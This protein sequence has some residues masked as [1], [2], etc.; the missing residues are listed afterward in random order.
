MSG[1]ED[2][3]GQAAINLI[4]ASGKAETL[5]QSKPIAECK[6]AAADAPLATDWQLLQR[7]VE[8]RDEAAFA[9]LVEWHGPMVFGVCRRVLGHTQDAED[10]F[11]ATFMA[12]ARRGSAL[13]RRG[14]LAN[15]LHRVA[16]NFAL[17]QREATARR[18]T[19]ET[20]MHDIPQPA[21]APNPWSD[22]EPLLDRELERLPEKYRAAILLCDIEG[23]TRK[24][25]AERLGWPEGTL[26]T[27]LLRARALLASRL[28]RQRI[29]LSAGTLA[30]ILAQNSASA[31]PPATLVSATV[32]AATTTAVVQTAAVGWVPLGATLAV[33]LS[34]AATALAA[35]AAVG[36][37]L[38]AGAGDAPKTAAANSTALLAE[39]RQS[40]EQNEKLLSP[41]TITF[42]K[43]IQTRLTEEET[44]KQLRC[45][46][47]E[48]KL[49]FYKYPS[50]VCWQQ[51]EIITRLELPPGLGFSKVWE[52]FCNGKIQHSANDNGEKGNVV[53]KDSI[54]RVAETIPNS[55][56]GAHSDYF[57]LAGFWTPENYREWTS[58]RVEPDLLH[59]LRSGGKVQSASQVELDGRQV[60][61]VEIIAE[62]P[63][64]TRAEEVNL[65]KYRAQVQPYGPEKAQTLIEAFERQR[66]VP[67]E[68]RFTYFLDPAMGYATVKWQESYESGKPV[69]ECICSDFERIG[70]R[71]LWLPRKCECRYREWIRRIH[72]DVNYP[73]F[74]FEDDFLSEVVEVSE[75]NAAPVESEKLLMA[76]FTPGSKIIDSTLPKAAQ[77][78][79]GSITYKVPEKVDDLP[80]AI[81]TAEKEGKVNQPLNPQPLAAA[82]KRKSTVLWIVAGNAAL[83]LLAGLYLWRRQRAGR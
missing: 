10:A 3:L 29:A 76:Y 48:S 33:K 21:A 80:A 59:R 9:E 32:Q 56:F 19:R 20:P 65:E 2:Y 39:V 72:V 77:V 43:Q 11:Q 17:K 7:F 53:F 18:R 68:K 52:K 49:M 40:L 70:E 28:T 12:L 58:P 35:S 38:L 74:P 79:G 62:N 57:R 51:P 46:E 60:V 27:R 71:A 69:V 8:A 16:R 55:R 36:V 25:A 66:K 81:A 31:A 63:V 24:Q 67:A 82:P 15:W 6:P 5:N 44:L 41:I 50:R 26:S 54:L 64:R 47:N 4:T 13:V 45:Y 23:N 14:Q 83:L 22:L 75:I 1:N 30:A 61:Q 78:P 73:V 42:T 34:I 37:W